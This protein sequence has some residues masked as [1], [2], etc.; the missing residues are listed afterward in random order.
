MGPTRCTSS[1]AA[2]GRR[3]AGSSSARSSARGSRSP[4]ACPGASVW[5]SAVHRSSRTESPTASFP[6]PEAAVS[7]KSDDEIIKTT[8]NTARFFTETRHVSWVLL[9]A[10]IVW[11]FIGYRA[12]PQRKD[13]DVRPREALVVVPWPG[14][15]SERVE[16][17]VIRKV[18]QRIAENSHV[19]TITSNT[20]T[21]VTYVQVKLTE[22]VKVEERG[23][24]FDDIKLKLDAIRDLPEGA[25]PITFVKDFGDTATLLLTMASPR[26]GG[27]ELDLRAQAIR[28]ALAAA[29]EGRGGGRVAII[30]G[31]PEA[32]ATPES[33]REFARFAAFARERGALAD[34]TFVDGPGFG[35]V[36]GTARADDAQL[37]ALVR[38]YIDTRLQSAELHPDVWTPM[39]VRDL[40][41]IETGLKAAAGDKYSYRQLRDF[42]DLIQR[43]MLGVPEVGKVTVAGLLDERIYL[44]YSQERLAA[45]GLRPGD[46]SQALASRNITTAGGILEAGGKKVRIDPSGELKGEKEIGG[47]L[48]NVSGGR[49]VYLRDLVDVVRTY[50]AP[51]RFMNDYGRRENGSWQRTR[52]VTLSIQMRAGRQIAAFD[53]A[54]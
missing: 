46:L 3:R 34:T 7:H 24:E 9:A 30:L 32:V 1:T 5:S 8:H 47:I 53:R 28:R 54:V 41:T 19:E 40:D 13:P 36:D 48:V 12:M 39:I 25:G 16:E 23:K 49:S 33:A 52:A 51:P 17:L 10:T 38:E 42:A 21:G 37:L 35:G 15:S 29:R 27:V 43:T 26:A 31:M 11:G 2:T 4:P 14:A 50:D 18:E 20:R 22:D 6:E 45:Y 44:D